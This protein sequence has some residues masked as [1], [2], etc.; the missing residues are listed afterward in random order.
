MSRGPTCGGWRRAMPDEL[1]EEFEGL[2]ALVRWAEGGGK[3]PQDYARI[4][5]PISIPCGRRT[6][7]SRD[8]VN[9]LLAGTV[10]A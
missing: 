6:R 5:R 3:W 1:P 9:M 8:L 7:R 2:A 4:I 10:P